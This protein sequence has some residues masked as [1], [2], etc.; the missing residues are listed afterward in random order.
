MSKGKLE[1][2]KE[3]DEFKEQMCTDYFKMRQIDYYLQ[4]A[5][6]KEEI[7]MIRPENFEVHHQFKRNCVIDIY[8]QLN[9]LGFPSKYLKRNV[10]EYIVPFSAKSEEHI[11]FNQSTLP[12]V[13]ET[14]RK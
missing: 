9:Y 8:H 7:G 11:Q 2:V 5:L 12:V 4:K 14:K 1:M 3:K 6:H 10:D 13:K